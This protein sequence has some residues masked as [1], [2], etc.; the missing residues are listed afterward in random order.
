MNDEIERGSVGS[1]FDEFLTEQGTL[2]ETTAQAMSRMKRLVDEART[3]GF[4]TRSVE[5]IREAARKHAGY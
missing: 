1:S 4:S 5:D 3:G 2:E